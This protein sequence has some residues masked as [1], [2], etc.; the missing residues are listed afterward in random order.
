[1]ILLRALLALPFL[2]VI[3]FGGVLY[4]LVH[5]ILVVASLSEEPDNE[6]ERSNP[7]R[8]PGADLH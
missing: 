7:G 2:I 3:L 8:D 6:G 5:A 4:A 1:M